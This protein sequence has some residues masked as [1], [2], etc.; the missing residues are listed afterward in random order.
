MSREYTEEEVRNIFLK[1]ISS[2]K[3]YWLNQNQLSTDDKMDGL[4]HSI[5]C[6]IDG[7][8]MLPSF[9][10]VV[11]PHPDD[12]QTYIKDGENYFPE[13]ESDCDIND[14]YLHEH[15]GRKLF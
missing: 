8:T 2:A 6:I 10:L 14:G 1:Q 4:V 3:S 13:E 7:C 15:W 5:L 9:N 12:K 11:C